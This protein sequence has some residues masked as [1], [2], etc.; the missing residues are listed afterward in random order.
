MTIHDLHKIEVK[1][2][3]FFNK[4]KIIQIDTISETNLLIIQLKIFY[5]M[6]RKIIIKIVNNFF[7]TKDPVLTALINQI[8]SNH[9]HE[10]NK[11]DNLELIQHHTILFFNHKTQSIHNSTNQLKCIT[12]FCCRIFYNNMK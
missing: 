9:I 3:H 2:I 12:K 6:M 1:M 4:T 8:F 10:M 11:Y 5:Q 7:Q